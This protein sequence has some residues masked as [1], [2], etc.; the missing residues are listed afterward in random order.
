MKDLMKAL[1]IVALVI[2]V[3]MG[4]AIFGGTLEKRSAIRTW[5]GGTH[6]NCGGEWELFSANHVRNDGAHY[7]YKCK[8]CKAVWETRVHLK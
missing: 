8:K 5:N 7:F 4:L 2:G 3:P 1:M 6:I